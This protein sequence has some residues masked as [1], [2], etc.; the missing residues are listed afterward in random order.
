MRDF[1]SA[2]DCCT[3]S[4]WTFLDGRN[5]TLAVL[6]PRRL[7]HHQHVRVC[8]SLDSVDLS[9]EAGY[10]VKLHAFT[11]VQRRKV[12]RL[13]AL[14]CSLHRRSDQHP[15]S[16]SALQV[17]KRDAFVRLSTVEICYPEAE[18]CKDL[19]HDNLVHS[20]IR[21]QELVPR[22]ADT[23]YPIKMPA[24]FPQLSQLHRWTA[25]FSQAQACEPILILCP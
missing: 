23:S 13:R 8:I 19:W 1:Q 25:Y 22:G 5:Q 11:D 24:C 4:A 20:T 17:P 7:C 6:S 14:C 21:V 10:V 9:D 15:S 18:A 2:A 16:V 12:K 3:G